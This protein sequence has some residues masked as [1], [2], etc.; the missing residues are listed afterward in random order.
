MVPLSGAHGGGLPRRAEMEG[1]RRAERWADALP[2][3][4]HS[5]S[6]AKRRAKR[7]ALGA[8]GA[9]RSA[10]VVGLG[11]C[12][13]PDGPYF[14]GRETV[15]SLTNN[16]YKCL[17]RDEIGEGREDGLSRFPLV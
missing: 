5:S 8:R 10:R 14:G 4:Q 15:F 2:A 9:G 11:D 12:G 6:F 7:L 17:T 16:L 3:S 13:H 1:R